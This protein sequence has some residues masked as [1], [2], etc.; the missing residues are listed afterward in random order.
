MTQPAAPCP[1]CELGTPR[2]FYRA[3]RIPVQSCQLVP[4]RDAAIAFPRGDLAL[5]FCDAC[6]FVTNTLYD[7]GILGYGEHYEATQ[8]YSP[9]FGAFAAK[10]AKDLIDRF[11]LRGKRVLEIGCGN[12]EFVTLM[13][14]LGAGSGIGIDP[15]YVP[16]R[17]T[18]PAAK[19][20]EYL[21]E[22]YAPK[23]AAIDADLVVCRH[24]LEHVPQTLEFLRLLRANLGSRDVPVV[25]E[26]PDT[27]RVYREVAFW[28]IYYEHCSYFT[29]G[30]LARALRLAGF[31]ITDLWLEF[32]DQY[33]LA[34][35]RRGDDQV[36]PVLPT[37]DN[38]AADAAL[39]GTF[40]AASERTITTW[41]ARLSELYARGARTVL[42]GGSSK[43]V[44]FLTMLG[45]AREIEYCVDIN[46]FKQGRFMPGTGHQ[47][48]APEFL[49]EYRPT[50]AIL[51]NPIY[52]REISQ[53][54]EK[55]GVRP[56][57]IPLTAP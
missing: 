45:I 51:T 49:A 13:C 2:H 30:S 7:E 9:T 21:R 53:Q 38:L 36:P 3:D 8:G 28:D 23:H 55:L 11:D 33:L 22:C 56:E 41:R 10:L 43:S 4:T 54:L 57:L 42:W 26:V 20:V 5:A 15:A 40:A 46:P 12:G 27:Q 1:N 14:E 32:G 18:R 6:G 17:V 31:L 50:H 35:A 24:T 29:P 16:G 25:F 44:G 48:V 39:V 37:D 52:T 34:A 19:R 47:I